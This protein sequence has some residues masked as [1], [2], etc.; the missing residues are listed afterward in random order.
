MADLSET[1][2]KVR[3]AVPP[4]LAGFIIATIVVVGLMAALTLFFRLMRYKWEPADGAEEAGSAPG[5]IRT[6]KKE[7][8]K[9]REAAR[10]LGFIVDDVDR[11]APVELEAVSAA[12]ELQRRTCARYVFPE[13]V[14]LNE[15]WTL[16]RRPWRMAD[17]QVGAGW[18]LER[19]KN[20]PLSEETLKLIQT[21]TRERRWE[22]R[23]LEIELSR[24][25]LTFYWDEF[26]GAREVRNLKSYQ[27]RLKKGSAE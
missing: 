4:E 25:T 12:E 14:E 8:Q 22:G 10:A 27:D 2:D 1:A 6:S 7:R 16:L 18:Q 26:G 11:D 19:R 23:F 9:T 13:H 21:L 5:K 17:D 20:T 24:N 15:E 3:D